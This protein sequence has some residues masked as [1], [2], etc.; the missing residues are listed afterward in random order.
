VLKEEKR[1][2][3][4]RLIVVATCGVLVW[5]FIELQKNYPETIWVLAGLAVLGWKIYA[6]LAFPILCGLLAYWFFSSSP[7]SSN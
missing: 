6:F 4:R 1:L 7:R 2:S 3:I 5:G